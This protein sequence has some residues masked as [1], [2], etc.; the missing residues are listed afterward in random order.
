MDTIFVLSLFCVFAAAVLM[1]L[2]LGTKIH[3]AIEKASDKAYY[4][5]TALSYITEK[6]RHCDSAD[7]AEISEFGGTSALVLTELYNDVEYETVIYVYDGAV[8][9]LFREKGLNFGPDAGSEIIK[10]KALSFA[11]VS[12][13]LVRID[14]TD[15]KGGSDST[16][17]Y[18]RSGGAA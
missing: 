6:L 8:R 18:L 5:R 12:D 13:G 17:V 4:S 2:I 11:F 15:P 7:S 14:Y 9:E 10:A 1:T 3:S 16:F